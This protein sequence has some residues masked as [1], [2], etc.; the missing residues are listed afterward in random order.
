MKMDIIIS[1]TKQQKV[2]YCIILNLSQINTII[3]QVFKYVH[4]I[5]LTVQIKICT[6]YMLRKYINFHIDIE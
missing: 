1:Y 4:T 2:H 3:Y 5:W 6:Q